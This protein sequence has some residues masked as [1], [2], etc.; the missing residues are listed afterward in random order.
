M[1]L[2]SLAVAAVAVALMG[3]GNN[4]PPPETVQVA[5]APTNAQILEAAGAPPLPDNPHPAELATHCLRVLGSLTEGPH[6]E[7]CKAEGLWATAAERTS[8]VGESCMLPRLAVKAMEV[9]KDAGIIPRSS[10]WLPDTVLTLEG[11]NRTNQFVRLSPYAF[12]GQASSDENRTA[13][14]SFALRAIGESRKWSMNAS[15]SDTDTATLCIAFEV[16]TDD[17]LRQQAR[18][19]LSCSNW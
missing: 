15:L 16:A 6:V 2:Q 14:I 11:C 5:S 19:A 17:T 3:C 8:P 7:R 1:N 12:A 9:A 4:S 18:E 13:F 10:G